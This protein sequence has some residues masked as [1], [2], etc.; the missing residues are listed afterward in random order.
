M[1]EFDAVSA[2]AEELGILYVCFSD[3]STPG[4]I[5]KT[6]FTVN[7]T[8]RIQDLTDQYAN[9]AIKAFKAKT[10]AILAEDSADAHVRVQR[11]VELFKA[12]DVKVG[13]N[14]FFPA[15]TVDLMPYLTKI[16]YVDPDVLVFWSSTNEPFITLAKQI[17]ELGGWGHTQLITSTSGE[18][19]MDLPGAQG[20]YMQVLWYPGKS[21][22]GAAKFENDYQAM[23]G[24]LPMAPL[25][26]YYNAL[27]TAIYAIQ[28]A[29]TDTDLVKIAQVARSGNLEWETPL[30]RAHFTQDG[31]S[32]LSPTWVQI[33]GQKMVHV[34]LEGE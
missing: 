31:W 29:G 34:S 13:Y 7:A 33:E 4:I 32:G 24:T 9:V 17:M 18:V 25:A 3:L 19:S 30:G 2:M 23:Y 16:K 5:A 12:A 27:W 14:Q 6:K 26:Y 28:M 22:P 1:A 11:Y 20:W 21:D 15:T 10:V 8:C